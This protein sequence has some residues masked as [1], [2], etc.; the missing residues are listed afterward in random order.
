[1]QV[2]GV[3]TRVAGFEVVITQA[4][5]GFDSTRRGREFRE[6]YRTVSQRP[7]LTRR[8]IAVARAGRA[9]LHEFGGAKHP[10]LLHGGQATR[11][12]AMTTQTD[13][14]QETDLPQHRHRQYA[15]THPR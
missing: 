10:L 8:A 7:V 2:L 3:W 12:L 15:C 11:S 14:D 9:R 5:Q 4:M 6:Q 1:M 13:R